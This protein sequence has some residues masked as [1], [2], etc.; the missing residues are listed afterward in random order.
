MSMPLRMIVVLMLGHC[1]QRCHLI[2]TCFFSKECV[3]LE[4]TVH[5][6]MQRVTH[7]DELTLGS[8]CDLR[9]SLLTQIPFQCG[10]RLYTS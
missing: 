1:L 8:I 5:R 3:S 10:D 2:K 9:D 6:M 4:D 7:Q